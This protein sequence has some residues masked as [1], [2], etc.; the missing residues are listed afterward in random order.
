MN[1]IKTVVAHA[2]AETGPEPYEVKLSSGHHGWTAD[3]PAALG[4][5]DTGPAPFALLLS[6]LGACTAIT[7]KMY[8]KNKNWPLEGVRV[9]LRQVHGGDRDVIERTVILAG[10]LTEAARTRLA[11]VVERTPVTLALKGGLDIRTSV[12]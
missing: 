6:S 10:E 7:L 9:E 8:A 4:G 11:A 3:E 5:G 1:E 2:V 12:R